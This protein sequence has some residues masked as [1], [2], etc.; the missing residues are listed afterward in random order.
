MDIFLS[1]ILFV[2]ITINIVI[3]SIILYK[4]VKTGKE[5]GNNK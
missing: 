5:D 4:M 3:L 1:V 2:W